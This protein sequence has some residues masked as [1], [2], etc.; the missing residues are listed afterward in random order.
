MGVGI[1]GEGV[2]VLFFFKPKILGA[3]LFLMVHRSYKMEV[4]HSLLF[5]EYK[6]ASHL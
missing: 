4:A 2:S 3:C 1:W 5:S 6:L